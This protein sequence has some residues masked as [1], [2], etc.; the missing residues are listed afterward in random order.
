VLRVEVKGCSGNEA[1]AELTPNEYAQSR[2]HRADY[3]ICIVTRA[4]EQPT[5]HAFQWSEEA[6]GWITE[7][8]I[9]LD[10]TERIG[11]VLKLL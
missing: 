7:T 9:R 8:A 3:R 2:T 6:D 4:L 10:V 11:A 5:L 1:V